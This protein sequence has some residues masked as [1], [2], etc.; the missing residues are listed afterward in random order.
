MDE[1][2]FYAKKKINNLNVYVICIKKIDQHAL[3]KNSFIFITR[4][5]RLLIKN[6]VIKTVLQ[7]PS[8]LR[9]ILI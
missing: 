4:N 7:N 2:I 9:L 3:Y 5:L 6:E 1:V 8:T